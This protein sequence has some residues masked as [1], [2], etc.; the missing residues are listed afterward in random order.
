MVYT[1]Y[2]VY[3]KMRSTRH[4]VL[5]SLLL[6]LCS[7]IFQGKALA[8]DVEDTFEE[9]TE[10][11]EVEVPVNVIAKDGTPIRDLTID[12]FKIFD[13]GEQQEVVGLRVVDLDV[14]EPNQTRLEIERAV[15]PAAR[16][17]FLLLFDLSFSRPTAV[18]QARE[19]ARRF[20]L[21][22]LHP[23]DLA[24][25]A[26]HTVENGGRL[27]VTFTPDRA[28]VIRAIDT[29]GA[30]RFMQL[31]RQDPLRF[32][33]EDP[34]MTGFQATGVGSDSS[35]LNANQ[36]TLVE[37]IRI[38]ANEMAKTEK[39]FNRGRISSWSRSMGGLARL[40]DNIKGRKQVVYFTQGW[41]G[42]QLFGRTP[43]A[44]DPKYQE[45]LQAIQRGQYWWVDTDNFY[46]N[47]QLQM[48]MVHMIEEFRRADCV[49][50]T[51]DISGLTADPAQIERNR[52]ATRAALFYIS[53]ESGG[54]LFQNANDFGSQLSKILERS[55]VT[56]LLTFRPQGVEWNGEFHRLKVKAD[57]PGSA[58]LSYRQGYY[59]PRPWQALHPLEKKLMASDAIASAETRH[60][61][62]IDLLTAA[63]PGSDTK[64]YLPII[65][66]VSGRDL[67]VG[68]EGDQLPVEFYTY[69]SD[70][71]GEMKDFFTQMVTLDLSTGRKAFVDTGLKYYGHL[72]LAPGK[73]LLR[74][75][76]RNAG[77]GR[78]GAETIAVNVPE[79]AEDEPVLL[80]PFFVEDS[81][82][83]FLVRESGSMTA[84]QKVV[85]PFTV[86]GEPYIPVVAPALKER[87]EASVCLVAYNIGEGEI[88]LDSTIVSEDGQILDSGVLALQER[89]I[90]GIQ[91]LDKLLATF[92][93]VGLEAGNYTLRVALRNVSSG[94]T[95]T[96]SVPFALGVSN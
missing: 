70:Q 8:Q 49:I 51:V 16:R 94:A 61:L 32:V 28:Q 44:D 11:L 37:H 89:T 31:A 59:A 50:Q 57:V 67:L 53:N 62:Q 85:Y 12:D 47:T 76:V 26:T 30:P 93:P 88:L 9:T 39:S 4:A 34:E 58:R 73:Y 63:F 69:A 33:L 52:Q 23:T 10:V 60:D 14:I 2:E 68:Q 78:S 75:L 3:S 15:P 64:A 91:G 35:A 96:N 6:V 95:D 48:D 19:A 55:T 90:T 38:I 41:D 74:V 84:P 83:W 72:D 86:N 81:K 80:P 77:T 79:Y 27:L 21:E 13:A 71:H 5:S 24:A 43:S 54:E 66:E 45:D 17:H 7:P 82:D 29:L 87:E 56:Y 18:V 92:R 46:G 25:V 1:D 36:Q 42:T 65:I 40:M 20:V 22:Q